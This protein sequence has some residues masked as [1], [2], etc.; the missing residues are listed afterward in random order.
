MMNSSKYAC[1]LL[2]AGLFLYADDARAEPAQVD[3]S[4]CRSPIR[5]RADGEPLREL[6]KKLADEMGFVLISNP[7]I[8]DNV[9]FSGEYASEDLFRQLL[10][11]HNTMLSYRKDESCPNGK[12][13]AEVVLMKDGEMSTS[14]QLE[15]YEHAPTPE[16]RV[17]SG[18]ARKSKDYVIIEDMDDHVEAAIAKKA[19][20]RKRDMTPEQRSEFMRLKK[21]KGKWRDH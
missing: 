9:D 8:S 15:R 10:R 6:L 12:V 5:V 2:F 1:A 17:Q 16:V 3:Y 20:A 13:I 18:A 19:P 21:E 7:Q 11:G 4:D 14:S